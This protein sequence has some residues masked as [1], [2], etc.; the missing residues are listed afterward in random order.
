M[1]NHGPTA[2]YDGTGACI[3]GGKLSTLLSLQV[4]CPLKG[5]RQGSNTLGQSVLHG[6]EGDGASKMEREEEVL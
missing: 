3:F 5:F 6:H 1:G 2:P 4:C